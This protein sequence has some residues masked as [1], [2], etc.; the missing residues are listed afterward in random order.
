MMGLVVVGFLG[1][2]LFLWA[3]M[4]R[5]KGRET[6]D[7]QLEKEIRD[8]IIWRAMAQG[9]RITREEAAAHGGRSPMDVERALMSLVAEGRATAEAGDDGGIVYRVD[10]GGEGEAADEPIAEEEGA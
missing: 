6:P 9:G 8:Q 5:S 7:S 3:R 2:G 4:R 1:I 10:V